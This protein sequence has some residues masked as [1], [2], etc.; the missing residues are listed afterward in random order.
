MVHSKPTLRERFRYRFD[1]F[2]SKGGRSIFVSLVLVFL[3]L[4]V[5]ISL[6]RGVFYMAMPDAPSQHARGFFHNVYIT[7]LQMTDPG[8]MAQD[9]VSSPWFKISAVLAGLAGVVLL[10]SLIAFIT[11]ALDQ[12]LTQL[13]K[14]HS[15]VIEQGH[16][17][18]LGWNDRV[19]EILRELV[20]ANESEKDP[21][22]VILAH[23]DKEEMDDELAMHIP[24]TLNTRVV[25]RSGSESSLANLDIVSVDTCK[26]VVVLATCNVNGTHDEVDQSDI[27]VIKTILALVTARSEDVQLNIVAEVFHTRNRNVAEAI[28]PDEVTTV[29]TNEILAKM[30]VQTSRSIGL[31]VVYGEILSFDG[32]EMYFYNANWATGSTFGSVAYHFP[33]GIPMGLRH[34]DGSLSI[35]PDPATVLQR[36]DKVL[37]L[38]ED[39]STIDYRSLPVAVARDLPLANRRNETGIERE[40]I[41]G[42][43]QKIE[44]ILR[45]YADY[46]RNGSIIDIMLRGSNVLVRDEIERIN[47]ELPG[48]ELSLIE[49]DPLTTEGLLAV[50]PFQYDNIIILSQGGGE[51]DD[52]ERT[53][54]QTII[55]LLLLR[56]IFQ[57]HADDNIKTKL[58]TEMLDAENQSLLNHTGVNEFIISNRFVSMLLAQI[59]EDRDIKSVYDDLFEE[60]GSEIYLKSMQ[61]YFDELPVEVSFAD[62]MGLAQ[63]RGEVALGVKKKVYERNVEAN[64]GVK[65][66]PEKNTMYK[67]TK[68][69]T[70]V[71]L[72]GD[73]T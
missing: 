6:I 15:R 24:M 49:E 62:L 53:D 52:A 32:C 51:T 1:G 28:S 16:T 2:M 64:Y 10:S 4:L 55:I 7:F 19:P 9:I 26:S 60:D 41:I 63:K 47:K 13:R 38:A 37:I 59:S 14:G 5:A 69:D 58:V 43:T 18:V 11:T 65:L 33:D 39:D 42:W 67:L 45:E 35:N 36:D 21:V 8:N 68:D 25:T 31:S 50:K 34:V 27:A 48:I 40:L 12:L 66:I 70:L 54:S 3:G 30:L 57:E 73:E 71:V 46:V 56:H 61:L 17:L 23:K 44:T 29:D 72:A 22:V 20:M